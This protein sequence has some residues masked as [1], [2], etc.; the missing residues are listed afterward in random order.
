MLHRA[1]NEFLLQISNCGFDWNLEYQNSF[2]DPLH[3]SNCEKPPLKTVAINEI[4]R[5]IRFMALSYYGL[6]PTL[7]YVKIETDYPNGIEENPQP[8]PGNVHD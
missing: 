3:L 7:S 4:G 5:F 2:D 8:C 6:G 1:T